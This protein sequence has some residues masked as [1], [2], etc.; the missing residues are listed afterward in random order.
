[1]TVKCRDDSNHRDKGLGSTLK[2]QPVI[3]TVAS[4][5]LPSQSNCYSGSNYCDNGWSCQESG[6]HCNNQNVHATGQFSQPHLVNWTRHCH[7][8]SV[9]TFMTT[10]RVS[11]KMCQPLFLMVIF[12]HRAFISHSGSCGTV[13]KMTS[14]GKL[15]SKILLCKFYCSQAHESLCRKWLVHPRG[16]SHKE[17]D[18]YD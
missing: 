12:S 3:F 17:L 14:E 4:K 7:V 13:V 15:M 16:R 10:L 9:G 1:M 18:Q 5:E 11:A 2:C 8:S 6:N